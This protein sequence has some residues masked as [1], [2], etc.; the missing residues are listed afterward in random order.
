MW[1]LTEILCTVREGLEQEDRL[2]RDQHA[3][4]GIDALRETELHPLICQS[5]TNSPTHQLREVYYPCCDHEVPRGSQRDRCDL[6]LLPDGKKTLYDPV[7]AHKELLSASGTL[8]EPVAQ[9]PEIEAFECDPRD[10]M[11]IEIKVIPQF[12]YVDGVPGPNAKYAHELLSG[13]GTDA[14]KLSADPLIAHAG[15]LVVLFNEIQEAG[16]HDLSIAMRE[17]LDRDLPVGM[18]EME[19]FPIVDRCGNAFCTLGLIPL[20]L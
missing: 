7:H 18:P 3:V 11:W 20:R 10:A 9:T 12:R 16:V 14:I 15:L 6:V 5:F 2:L 4:R 8:F 17:L 13:P 1:S 19:T